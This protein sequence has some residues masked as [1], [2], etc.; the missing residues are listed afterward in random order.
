MEAFNPTYLHINVLLTYALAE[1]KT[2]NRG[3]RN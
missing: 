1:D 3:Q 2:D